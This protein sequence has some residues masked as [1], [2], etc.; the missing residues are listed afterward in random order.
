MSTLGGTMEAQLGQ[1][2]VRPYINKLHAGNIGSFW[3]ENTS[4]ASQ[5]ITKVAINTSNPIIVKRTTHI[6]IL[7]TVNANYRALVQ[8]VAAHICTTHLTMTTWQVYVVPC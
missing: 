4:T 7:Y 8:Y 1:C 6:P 5:E 3:K 2:Y